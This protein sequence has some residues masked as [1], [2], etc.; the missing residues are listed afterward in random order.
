[1]SVFGAWDIR[2]STPLGEQVGKLDIAPA[3]QDGFTGRVHG[4]PGE[5]AIAGQVEC[6][7]LIWRMS[8]PKPVA[9]DLDCEARA[10][11]DRLAGTLKAG[12]FGGFKLTGT[13]AHSR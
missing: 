3:G 7:R 4:G 1:M 5:M 12:F 9:M 6:D 2:I 11:G 10:D 8:L 13:R